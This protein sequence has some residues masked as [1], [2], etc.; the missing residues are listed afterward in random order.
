MKKKYMLFIFCA[1][2]AFTHTPEELL[3]QGTKAQSLGEYRKALAIFERLHSA[4]PFYDDLLFYKA[5]VLS[6]M[7]SY[8]QAVLLYQEY[9]KKH[10]DDDDCRLALARVFFWSKMHEEAERQLLLLLHINPLSSEAYLMLARVYVAQNRL[11]KADGAIRYAELIC[12]KKIVDEH[13]SCTSSKHHLREIA[14]YAHYI[15]GML[16]MSCGE[17]EACID[18]CIRALSIDQEHEESL[19]LLSKA[20]IRN[21]E[22][23]KAYK[24]LKKILE[25]DNEHTD[26][27]FLLATLFFRSNKMENARVELDRVLENEPSH[28]EGKILA[29]KI[30]QETSYGSVQDEAQKLYEQQQYIKARSVISTLLEEYPDDPSILLLAGNI[31]VALGEYKEAMQFFE[32]A[33][34]LDPED[35]ECKYA[36]GRLYLLEGKYK[37]A[38]VIFKELSYTAPSFDVEKALLGVVPK[39]RSHFFVTPRFGVEEEKDLESGEVT[40]RN[41]ALSFTSFLSVSVLNTVKPKVGFTSLDLKQKNLVSDRTNYSFLQ[42]SP[43]LGVTLFPIPACEI[44]ALSRFSYY[45]SQS[46]ES[47]FPF[48]SSYHWEP[49]LNIRVYSD[50]HFGLLSVDKTGV[51]SRRFSMPESFITPQVELSSAYEYRFSPPYS[52]VGASLL[53]SFFSGSVS[54]TSTSESIWVRFLCPK[55]TWLRFRFEGGYATYARVVPAYYSF[56]DDWHLQGKATFFYEWN[57]KGYIGISYDARFDMMKAFSNQGIAVTNPEE[58]IPQVIAKTH[59]F[60]NKLVA[61]GWYIVDDSFRIS[62]EVRAAQVN[63]FYR[64]VDGIVSLLYSF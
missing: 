26:A 33:R 18:Q 39:A 28:L 47:I 22:D 27:H 54:N 51:P 45:S 3:Q 7:G 42:L 50:Q 30:D 52:G 58:D 16:F 41:T 38:Y 25:C 14:L 60:T 55:T 10:P 5:R 31:A 4:N 20:Y 49:S 53:G 63:T 35:S 24:T 2:V 21:G 57:P 40:T 8:S 37:S 43:Y 1:Q 36:L 12:R 19:F 6:W 23:K 11:T 9:L 32:K 13:G 29:Q 64:S 56:K 61:E 62:F 34:A 46:S 17:I 59:L 44:T 48:R 15:H